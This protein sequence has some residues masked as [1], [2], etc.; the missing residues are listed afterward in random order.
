M[1]CYAK[2]YIDKNSGEN[3]ATA[4]VKERFLIKFMKKQASDGFCMVILEN[5][6]EKLSDMTK[7]WHQHMSG[8]CLGVREI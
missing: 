5:L 8:V 6:S 7:H 3:I 1:D 4:G 2:Y